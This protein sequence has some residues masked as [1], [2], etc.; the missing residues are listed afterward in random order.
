MIQLVWPALTQ[1]SSFRVHST[2]FSPR[3]TKSLRLMP[4]GKKSVQRRR[5]RYILVKEITSGSW[6]W[7]FYAPH[8]ISRT[9]SSV[10]ATALSPSLCVLYSLF[11]SSLW[12]LYSLLYSVPLNS[13]FPFT[14]SFVLLSLS[15]G[16]FRFSSSPLLFKRFFGFHVF[17][18]IHF[19]FRL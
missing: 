3:Q 6:P 5:G 17:H 13:L 11:Y 14:L 7:S 1:L 19:F 8:Y 12:P 10:L 4:L 18:R 2:E 9:P 16:W 15:V